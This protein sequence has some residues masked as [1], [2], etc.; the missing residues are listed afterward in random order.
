MHEPRVMTAD[1]PSSLMGDHECFLD[2]H[3]PDIF[4]PFSGLKS[5]DHS[6]V[7]QK[8]FDIHPDFTNLDSIDPI[9][10]GK[11]GANSSGVFPDW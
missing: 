1:A 5:N 6:G 9:F 4:D 8:I 11:M 2:T 10:L 7:F 3:H